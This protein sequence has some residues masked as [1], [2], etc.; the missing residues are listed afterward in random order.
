LRNT[1]QSNAP[2]TAPEEVIISLFC[3]YGAAIQALQAVTRFMQHH[4]D[5]R[6]NIVTSP[7]LSPYVNQILGNQCKIHLVSHNNPFSLLKAIL[8]IGVDRADYGFNPWSNGNDGVFFAS[9]AKSM[10]SFSALWKQCTQNH[11]TIEEINFHDLLDE[12][13]GN[14]PSPHTSSTSLYNPPYPNKI[15][16]CPESSG[17]QRTLTPPHTIKLIDQLHALWPDALIS[18]AASDSEY[19]PATKQTAPT[20]L[21]LNKSTRSSRQLIDLI[22]QSDL[23]VAVDSGPLNIAIALNR[24]V[25]ALFS[26]ELP[27]RV[28]PRG[29][30]KAIVLRHKHMAGVSCQNSG[31]MEPLCLQGLLDNYNLLTP[32]HIWHS[33]TNLRISKAGCPWLDAHQ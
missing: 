25:M 28:L 5:C 2:P 27:E 23:V 17:P 32:E 19:T 30:Q 9:L 16:L 4:P 10:R 26:N 21:K 22:L 8:A 14:N 15:L 18:I 24:P 13:F 7:Q 29:L 20:F 3:R 11:N 6:I 33:E 1:I 31:C 12:Y